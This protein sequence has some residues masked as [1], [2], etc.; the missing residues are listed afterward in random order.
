MMNPMAPTTPMPRKTSF[1]YRENSSQSDL[2][3]S[4]TVFAALLRKLRRPTV[5]SPPDRENGPY[6]SLRVCVRW[7]RSPQRGVVQ[8]LTSKARLKTLC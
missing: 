4:F 5:Q 3:E 2:R 8:T 6:I 1:R 7:R